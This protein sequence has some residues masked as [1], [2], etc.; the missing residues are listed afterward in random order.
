MM[1]LSEP[2]LQTPGNT[3]EDTCPRR[4]GSSCVSEAPLHH[5]WC[6]PPPPPPPQEQGL[7]GVHQW[8][9]QVHQVHLMANILLLKMFCG[10]TMALGE[11]DWGVTHAYGSLTGMPRHS[12][13]MYGTESSSLNNKT[14]AF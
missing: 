11:C 12:A 13:G 1:T 9:E 3:L 4:A 8:A 10:E 2:R 5:Q 14:H 6:C 7:G